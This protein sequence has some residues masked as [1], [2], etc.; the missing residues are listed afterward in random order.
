[1]CG[2]VG[3]FNMGE[4]PPVKEET[5]S[6]MLGMLRHRGPDEFGIYIDDMVG[7]GNARL[8][9]VDLSGGQQP[10]GNEDGGIWIVFNGEI[11]NHVELR[12][13]L[14]ARGH[15]FSTHTDTEVILHLYEE[16]GP[17]C[18]SFLNGQFAMAIWDSREKTLF[19]A[20]DRMGIRPLFFT[21]CDGR[22][23]FGSEIKA[24]LAH[25][26]VRAELDP[27]SLVQ[28]FTY[29]S[30][31]SPKTAF[32]GIRDVPPG[33]YLLARP[34]R[35]TVNQYWRPDF[36]EAS[37]APTEYECAE[38]LESILTDAT[39]IRLR[40]DVPVGA[41]LSGGLDSSL[42][43]A[44]VRSRFQN[45]LET[46]SI[47][48]VDNPEFDESAFQREMAAY[49]GTEHR[50]VECTH[51]DIG[52]VFPEVVWHAET[53]L[54]R[55]APAPMFL[56]SRLVR[57]H[58]LKVVLTGEGADEV[59]GGYDIFKEMKIRR[60]WAREPASN[61]RPRLLERLY[62]EIRGLG[63]AGGAM[64]TAFFRKGLE[65][66]ASPYYSHAIRWQN[67]S[68]TLRFL[69]PDPSRTGSDSVSGPSLPPEFL[70]WSPLAQAQYLEMTVFLAQYLLSA[71]GDR[72]A[73]A[74][75]VEGRYPFLDVRVVEFGGRLPSCLKL[76]GLTE[77]WILRQVGRKILPS[78]IWKRPKR[79][80]RAPIQKSFFEKRHEYV[81]ELLSEESVRESGV[82]DPSAVSRLTRKALSRDR[83][84]EVDEMAL[85]GILSTQLV[86]HYFIKNFKI[87]QLTDGDRVKIVNGLT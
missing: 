54:L 50:V 40:A 8:S 81:S 83:L 76:R 32:T 7:M 59:F 28:I 60:F 65:D 87:L 1:M 69:L 20:R 48:F 18:L 11:F 13:G 71:Q 82:F 75:S 41:Y 15:R 61:S 22:L 25:P 62:P 33:H 64:M 34:G 36:L 6:G 56:L 5:L 55:T 80:Y 52:R 31:L 72:M 78:A 57:E 85:V 42:T 70:R 29:W 68:R 24:V 73:M 10:I 38:E 19:L 4:R 51:A 44:L 63:K 9:I 21:E 16:H 53:P 84:G 30:T 26:G 58:G 46:F 3:A 67:T 86:H 37:C 49:L 79:P 43:A 39:R 17:G 47:A 45:R 23:V 66:T 12:P 2:I 74:H 27:A 35:F 77:K 14:E